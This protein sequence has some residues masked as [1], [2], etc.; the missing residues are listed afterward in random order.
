MFAFLALLIAVLATPTPPTHPAPDVIL[1]TIDGTRWQE[2]YNGSDRWR[3]GGHHLTP[4][5]V[6]PNLYT[7]FVDQGIAVGKL[8][9]MVASGPNHISLPGYLEITRGHP[10][11]DCQS[12]TCSPTIDQSVFWFFRRSAVLG[13]WMGIDKT[14][15]HYSHIYTN[16]GNP[17]RWDNETI[18]QAK[19]YLQ[20]HNPDFLWVAL[21][22]TDELAHQ[23]SYSGYLKALQTSDAFIGWLVERYPTSTIIVTCDHGRNM[24]FRDHGIDKA[25]ERVWLMMRGPN[26]PVK[27]TVSASRLSLSNILPTIT[28][29]EFGSHSL[30]SIL[31]KIH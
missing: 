1:V 23:N 8:T 11:T 20:D 19:A 7:Y 3:D 2:I 17:Y 4:R 21:G 28:D 31:S 24:D 15:P 27:G 22:D 26:V 13:S 12:N 5:Q 14:V 25:S 9:P 6:V 10:S 30:D 29:T 16:I 18:T